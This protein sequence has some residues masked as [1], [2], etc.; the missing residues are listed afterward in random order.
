MLDIIELYLKMKGVSYEKLTGSV[1]NSDR[2]SAIQRFNNDNQ[3]NQSGQNNFGVF[4]LTTRAGGLGI[5]LTSARVVIIF[6]SDWNPQNDL[7]AIAR[8]HRIGQKFEVQ[9][10]RL[11]TSKTYE[12][13]MFERASKKLGMEQALFSKG[14]FNQNS[15]ADEKIAMEG[16]LQ[17]RPLTDL[18][19]DSKEIENLLK[20]GAYAFMDNNDGQNGDDVANLKNKDIDEILATGKKKEFQYNKGVYTL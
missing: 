17:L 9:V 14:A 1:K 13:Q 12:E 4:L 6:D 3:Q 11:I 15:S 18:K 19:Q 7:Q 2:V 16:G 8:A 5:N 10:Y 20:Y